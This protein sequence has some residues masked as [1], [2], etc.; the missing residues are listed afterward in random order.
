AA[1]HPFEFG[2]LDSGAETRTTGGFINQTGKAGEAH[3]GIQREPVCDLVLV[4]EE[5]HL[6]ISSSKIALAEGITAAIVGDEVKKRVVALAE[7]V[8]PEFGV[9]A[10]F[11]NR[12]RYLAAYVRR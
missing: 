9:V 8:E 5:N 6:Q 10:A 2:N 3:A 4:F 7:A 1:E 12:Q 11:D